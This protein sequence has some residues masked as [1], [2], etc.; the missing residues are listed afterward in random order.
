MNYHET[1]IGWMVLYW[2]DIGMVVGLVEPNL[3]FFLPKFLLAWMW[4]GIETLASQGVA[5]RGWKT[6]H[7]WLWITINFSLNVIFVFPSS[8]LI[9]TPLKDKLWENIGV[10]RL[11]FWE[12][13]KVHQIKEKQWLESELE[14]VNWV[15]AKETI[16]DQRGNSSIAL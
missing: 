4:K 12:H 14:E 15:G 5:K 7:K 6:V 8:L 10:L 1:L 2:F 11:D 13:C 16:G 3:T 9:K